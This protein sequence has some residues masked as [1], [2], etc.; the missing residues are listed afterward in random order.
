MAWWTHCH[1]TEPPTIIVGVS[2][3]VLA[4]YI[5]SNRFWALDGKIG[6]KVAKIAI[7]PSFVSKNNLVEST[8]PS[9]SMLSQTYLAA[10]ESE[11]NE[12]EVSVQE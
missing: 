5:A 3:G 2:S 11:Q 12:M 8:P 10:K 4:T 6:Q 1:C 7:L 9:G